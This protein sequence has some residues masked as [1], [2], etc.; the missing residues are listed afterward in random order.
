VH[1]LTVLWQVEAAALGL[2][3]VVVVFILQA[4]H[5]RKQ[6]PSLRDLAEKIWLPAL[7]Y[8]GLFGIGLIAV[9]LLGGGHGAPGGWAASWALLWAVLPALGLINLFIQMLHAIEPE[10]L[11][12]LWLDSIEKEMNEQIEADVLRRIAYNVLKAVC[13]ASEVQPVGLLGSSLSPNLEAITASKAGT[14]TDINLRRVRRAGLI[15]KETRVA[16]THGGDIPVVC[17]TLGDRVGEGT[18]LMRLAR[19]IHQYVT[20][21]KAFKIEFASTEVDLDVLLD[22]LQDEALRLIRAGSP[23]AYGRV[24]D[25]YERLLLVYPKTWARYKQQLVGGFADGLYLVE[26]TP[27]RSLSRALHT[28][29]E[30]AVASGDFNIAQEALNLPIRVAQQAATLDLP[31]PALVDEMLNVFVHGVAEAARP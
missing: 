10:R 16:E 20:P 13:E 2:T 19:V 28:E 30:A 29:V 6:R 7:F 1:Y 12:R 11:Y 22:D 31:A 8:S 21:R 26:W 17:V 24:N 3:L 15:S 5:G 4:V 27:G 23:R 25:V 14:V 9:V 18:I